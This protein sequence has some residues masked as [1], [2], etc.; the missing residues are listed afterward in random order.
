MEGS[1][2][3]NNIQSRSRE[4][5]KASEDHIVPQ[6]REGSIRIKDKRG[7]PLE[8]RTNI[9]SLADRPF[10]AFFNPR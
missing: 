3:S 1:N 2:N 7:T 6:R 5:N 9:V 8:A 4:V 10:G